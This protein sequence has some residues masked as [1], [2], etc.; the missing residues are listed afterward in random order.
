MAFLSSTPEGPEKSVSAMWEV[1]GDFLNTGV[2]H[3]YPYTSQQWV[4]SHLVLPTQISKYLLRTSKLDC[5]PGHKDR[6]AHAGIRGR[7]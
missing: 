2:P 4:V 5:V 7:Q 6:Q 1:G 3:N